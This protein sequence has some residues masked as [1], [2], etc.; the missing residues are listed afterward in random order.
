[1]A[2]MAIESDRAEESGSAGRFMGLRA[3]GQMAEKEL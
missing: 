1:M 3:A 2:R